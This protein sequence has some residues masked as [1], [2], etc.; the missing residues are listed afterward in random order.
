[1]A[2]QELAEVLAA[3]QAG[4]EGYE[5]VDVREPWEEDLASLPGFQLLPLSRCVAWE[6]GLA[7]CIR[8]VA[9]YAQPQQ[10]RQRPC[11]PGRVH[12]AVAQ[13]PRDLQPLR[14]SNQQANH[15]AWPPP[16]H[17]HPQV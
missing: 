4:A 14:A 5:F 17:P 3:A 12:G 1:M 10:Q 16:L 6:E 13:P 7:G 2:V 8:D 9:P 15:A 11:L